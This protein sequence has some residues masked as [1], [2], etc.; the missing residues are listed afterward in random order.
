MAQ[1]RKNCAKLSY[2]AINNLAL[3]NS[4]TTQFFA[5]LAE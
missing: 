2:F 4:A 1:M 3:P 5:H